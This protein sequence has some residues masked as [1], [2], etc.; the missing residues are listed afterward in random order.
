MSKTGLI[1]TY[2][3]SS[4]SFAMVRA[5]NG[6]LKRYKVGDRIDGGIV[7]AITSSEMRYQK[8]GRMYALKV[9]SG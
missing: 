4:N 7:A 2:V 6:R 1:G 9:P 8:G 5:S 3:S